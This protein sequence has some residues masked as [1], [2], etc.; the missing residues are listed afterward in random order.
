MLQPRRE[1]DLALEPIRGD[2]GAELRRQQL[3][4]DAAAEARFF[5]E[6][7]TRHAAA[8]QFSARNCRSRSD[9][10]E[11]ARGD[12]S[13]GKR[14]ARRGGIAVEQRYDPCHFPARTVDARHVRESLE[15]CLHPRSHV[16]VLV[17]IAF[18]AGA[19]TRSG[20]P[21]LPGWYADPEAHVFDGQY[22]IFPTYSAPYDQQTFMDAFS[23]RD[24][25]TW[26]KHSR[27]LDI[28]SVPWA[29]ARGVGAFDR[30]EGG[31]Y[32]L[33]FGANDIQKDEESA[34]SASRAP[35]VP[36]AR[37]STTSAS[38]SSMRSTTARSRS[39]RWCSRI[40]MARITSSMAAGG[41]A[42]S[43]S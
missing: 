22:W 6:K 17:A 21:I 9:R 3:Y 33:F 11:V 24:L 5:S 31:W 40:V 43:R 32:Y 38:R 20:N 12:R 4:D 42:T 36:T 23:S 26:E 39:I 25:V 16:V 29:A 10:H 37:S 13:N 27:I 41:T 1:L 35:I 18:T 30:R 15:R 8:A 19:Q 28:A 14:E 2:A 7:D 34:A